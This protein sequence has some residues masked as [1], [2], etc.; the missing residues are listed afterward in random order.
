M[1]EIVRRSVEAW[2]RGATEVCLQGG[3][4][5]EESAEAALFRELHEEV[6]LEE[7]DVAVIGA[8]DSAKTGHDKTALMFQIS[9]TPG[10]LADV[11]TA[12]KVNKINLTWIESFPSPSAPNEYLFFAEFEGHQAD[13][14]PRRARADRSAFPCRAAP[15][16]SVPRGASGWRP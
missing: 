5:P 14:N 1:S 13:A 4:H 6:G 10:S 8:T 15:R 9:H 2:D 11:L 7:S 12:F 16:R 3:I